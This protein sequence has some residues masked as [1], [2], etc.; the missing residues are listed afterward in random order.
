MS[1]YRTVGQSNCQTKELSDHNYALI[2][3]LADDL[4]Y[5]YILLPWLMTIALWV[6]IFTL[7]TEYCI[8]GTDF[9]PCQ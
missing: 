6:H 8:V 2:F 1:D 3:T 9:Y 5:V 4:N 7:A